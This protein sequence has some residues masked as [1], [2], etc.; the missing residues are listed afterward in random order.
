MIS[1]RRA[2]VE[3]AVTSNVERLLKG[4]AFAPGSGASGRISWKL[5][6]GQVASVGFTLLLEPERGCLQLDFLMPDASDGSTPRVT[7]KIS[8]T[9]TKMYFGGRRWWFLCPVS[10]ERVGCSKRF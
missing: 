8:V 3:R 6:S 7:Q 2:Y 10:G 4:G 5:A 1:K 9:T